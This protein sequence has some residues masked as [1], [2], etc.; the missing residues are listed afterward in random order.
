MELGKIIACINNK[1]NAYFNQQLKDLQLSYGQALAINV[2]YKYDVIQQ[3]ILTNILEIDKSA[4]TRILKTLEEKKFIEK[5]V[6]SH[7]HRLYEITLTKKGVAVYPQ[8]RKIIDHT[9]DTM[10][11][12]ISDEEA[13]ILF[14]L[15]TKIKDNLEG[16]YE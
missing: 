14:D 12:G 6:N 9:R 2:I 5:H 11:E 10:L 15:L 16:K 7:D 1:K 13:N 8:I 3:D 4:V